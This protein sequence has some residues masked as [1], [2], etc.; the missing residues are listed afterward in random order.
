[1][2]V[3]IAV[4]WI[5]IVASAFVSLFLFELS[6]GLEY[7]LNRLTGG[8]PLPRISGWFYPT[9]FWPYLFPVLWI[10]P[11]VYA[12][13]HLKRFSKIWTPFCLII[14]ALTLVFISIFLLA[15]ALPWLSIRIESMRP[16]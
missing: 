4:G 1:M 14:L 12:T 10:L 2:I 13:I 6:R 11:A 7:P 3:R 5:T 15:I 8:R 9:S 16:S